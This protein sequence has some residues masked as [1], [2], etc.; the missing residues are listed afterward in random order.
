MHHHHPRT[1]VRC[2]ASFGD[3]YG[4]PQ[5]YQSQGAVLADSVMCIC[6]AA[7]TVELTVGLTCTG[8]DYG[9]TQP[10]LAEKP[11]N[12]YCYYYSPAFAGTGCSISAGPALSP[13]RAA[14][15]T[16]SQAA[17]S[18]AW[19]LCCTPSALC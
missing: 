1:K 18:P 4:A 17:Y 7:A 5:D 16:L 14:A 19:P 3:E 10:C 2:T 11:V 12:Y 13:W 8:E 9:Q 15:Q 6:W